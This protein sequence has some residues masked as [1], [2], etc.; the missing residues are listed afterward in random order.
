MKK[1]IFDNKKKDL[2]ISCHFTIKESI[3][4]KIKKT[5]KDNG[6]SESKVVNTI[7]EEYFIE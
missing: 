1:D 2:T 3:V 7:L 4:K 6:I 5:A